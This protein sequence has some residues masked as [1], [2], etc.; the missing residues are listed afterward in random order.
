MSFDDCLRRVHRH[1]LSRFRPFAV[2]GEDVGWVRHELARELAVHEDVFAVTEERVAL[3]DELA[4]FDARTA[5][6]ARPSEST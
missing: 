4:D 5:A 6:L 3:R 2:A 1:D